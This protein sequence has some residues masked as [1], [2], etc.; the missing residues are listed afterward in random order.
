MLRVEPLSEIPYDF[1]KQE[2]IE[3]VWVLMPLD[4]AQRDL[5]VEQL[6]G[7]TDPRVDVMQAIRDGFHLDPAYPMFRIG[8]VAHPIPLLPNLPKY[9]D[10]PTV[11]IDKIDRPMWFEVGLSGGDLDQPVQFRPLRYRRTFHLPVDAIADIVFANKYQVIVYETKARTKQDV[12]FSYRATL[13]T[14]GNRDR[15]WSE[16]QTT[17]WRQ[18][19]VPL[20]PVGD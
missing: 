19:Q 8:D 18:P 12:P 7:L 11:L 2:G 14:N 13:I 1:V 16:T 17:R 10:Q 3:R 20:A 4:R 15:F 5:V 6:E 9:W